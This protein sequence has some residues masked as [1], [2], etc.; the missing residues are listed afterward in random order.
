MPLI[1]FSDKMT[2]FVDLNFSQNVL[3]YACRTIETKDASS[4]CYN[5]SI[6][7]AHPCDPKQTN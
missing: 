6:I 4:K 1:F 3:W 2:L 5:F 7:S